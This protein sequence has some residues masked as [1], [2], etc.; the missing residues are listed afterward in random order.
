MW[1]D[2]GEVT[3]DTRRTLNAVR[4]ALRNGATPGE[5][6][7]TQGGTLPADLR[8]ALD[9]AARA[10]DRARRPVELVLRT[11]GGPVHLLLTPGPPHGSASETPVPSAEVTEGVP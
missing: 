6:L 10:T 1:L 7:N 2:A 8:L 3:A 4:Q 9:A 5:A 11:L